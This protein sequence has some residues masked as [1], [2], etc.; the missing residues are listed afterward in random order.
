[1]T[2]RYSSIAEFRANLAD[3]L[4]HAER[5]ETVEVERRGTRFV[6][7][8]AAVR[9]QAKK[10]SSWYEVLDPKLLDDGWTWA[11]DGQSMELQVG[12]AKARPQKRATKKK[13]Q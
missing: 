6:L 7:E 4:D 13:H 12:P 10:A 11:Y 9:R 8:L 3:A 5:G 1:M 2:R